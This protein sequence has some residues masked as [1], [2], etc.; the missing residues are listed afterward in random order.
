MI[1]PGFE[2]QSFPA[3]PLTTM[4]CSLVLQD[5]SS[6]E[7]QRVSEASGNDWEGRVSWLKGDQATLSCDENSDR[8]ISI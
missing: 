8:M 5:G 7:R 1:G 4:V 3:K 2:L 6:Q